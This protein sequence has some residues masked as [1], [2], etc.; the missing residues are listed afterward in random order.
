MQ[1]AWVEEYP[2]TGHQRGDQPD[3]QAER[4]EQRQ[5]GHKAIARGEIRNGSD[6][7]HVGQQAGM[8]MH[9]ALRM[10]FRA[11]GKQDQCCILWLLWHHCL[12]WLEQVTQDPQLIVPGD[13]IFQIFQIDPVSFRHLLWQMR[14]FALFQELARGDDGFNGGRGHRAFQPIHTGGVIEHGRNTAPQ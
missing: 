9:Y 8:G 12:M 14:Q 13:G 3:C 5:R 2:A 11:G 7:L 4:V 10:A 1:R 6:L